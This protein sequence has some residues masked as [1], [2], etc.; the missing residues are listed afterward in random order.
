MLREIKAEVGQMKSEINPIIEKE[1]EQG[2]GESTKIKTRSVS[3]ADSMDLGAY[4]KNVLHV[5]ATGKFTLRTRTGISVEAKMEKRTV[6]RIVEHLKTEGLVASVQI[7]RDGEPK[8]RW[9]IT[10]EARSV[11]AMLEGKINQNT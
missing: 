4:A 7:L 11:L 8:T 1:T 2:E 10:P 5:L 6:N 3:P 9:H